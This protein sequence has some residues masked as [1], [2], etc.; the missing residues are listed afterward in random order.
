MGLGVFCP[1]P[2]QS[3]RPSS[4]KNEVTHA[5]QTQPFVNSPYRLVYKSRSEDSTLLVHK[6][7]SPTDLPP[8]WSLASLHLFPLS[9]SSSPPLSIIIMSDSPLR[10]EYRAA[11]ALNNMAV[12]LHEK[13][14]DRQAY[15]TFRDALALIQIASR[16]GGSCPRIDARIHAAVQR[17]AN[18]VPANRNKQQRRQPQHPRHLSF[19]AVS[20]DADFAKLRDS[21]SGSLALSPHTTLIRVEE[22]GTSCLVQRDLD[23]DSSIILHNY[24]LSCLSQALSLP[25][26]KSAM[27]RRLS[28]DAVKL[29]QL[30]Q[31]VVASRSHQP[32][33]DCLLHKLFLI[34]TVATRSQAQAFHSLHLE[35]KVKECLEQLDELV[36]FASGLLCHDDPLLS[37][38]A[39][40]PAA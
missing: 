5:P 31:A 28:Q 32:T 20:D 29:L 27:A 1:A 33:D 7:S 4:R 18:P 23:L 3:L 39:A 26:S 38:E 21:N 10:R 25:P 6:N 13:R 24:G 15:E 35:W 8:F 36:A 12:F 9:S 14:C 37:Q 34:A 19:S 22:Y 40:A 11:I 17:L 30:S 16:P 2:P